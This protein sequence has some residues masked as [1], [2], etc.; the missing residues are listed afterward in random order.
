MNHVE[1]VIRLFDPEHN[2]RSIA[3]KLK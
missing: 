2:I 1:T 3:A